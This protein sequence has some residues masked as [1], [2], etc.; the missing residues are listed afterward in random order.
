MSNE[1]NKELVRRYIDELWNKGNLNSEGDF[2]AA[3][4]VVHEPSPP[5]QTIS[6]V[7]AASML[8]AAMPDLVLVNEHLFG[9]GDRVVQHWA[10]SG[11]HS[12]A[13]LF[14]IP[15]SNRKLV[16]SGVNMFRVF[17]GKISERWSIMDAAGL[18]QQ[19]QAN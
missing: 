14:G 3:N 19:L 6:L 7:G 18:M 16:V 15:A 1:S 13:A 17:E 11:V 10:A 8:R 5:G 12:G 2:V 4:I 9:D